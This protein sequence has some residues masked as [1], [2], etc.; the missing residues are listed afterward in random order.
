MKIGIKNRAFL[1]WTIL[2]WWVTCLPVGASAQSQ[3][4][5]ARSASQA[6]IKEFFIEEP[7]A[8]SGY[9]TGP[10]HIIYSDGSEVVKTLPPLKPKDILNAVAFSNVRLAEDRQTLGWEINIEG[11][12]TSY[13]IPITVVVFRHKHVLH[14]FSPG[15]GGQPMILEWRFLRGGKQV[16][17]TFGPIH[18]EGGGVRI[19]DV[20]TGRV[21]TKSLD[22][23]P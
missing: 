11:C 16:E 17:T 20:K 12:C 1:R 21:L 14:T 4:R 8:N 23:D 3:E 10:L 2:C 19:Y 22:E 5:Q 13:S 15:E 6:Y 7:Q 9:E 18:G